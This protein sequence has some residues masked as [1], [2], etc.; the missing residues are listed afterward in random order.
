LYSFL[1]ALGQVDQELVAD[2][3]F[4]L[5]KPREIGEVK[6][7]KAEY[8]DGLDTERFNKYSGELYGVLVSLTSNEGFNILKGMADTG[9]AHD[10]YKGLLLLND[11]FDSRT[12]AGLLQSY[13]DAVHPTGLKGPHDVVPG[14]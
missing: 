11:R 9:E 3:R 10:G 4:I 13:L 2:L 6:S 7:W 14:I 5:G 1:V 12:A 8:E